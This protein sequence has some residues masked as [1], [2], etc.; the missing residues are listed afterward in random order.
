MLKVRKWAV[1]HWSGQLG[2]ISPQQ[3]VFLMTGDKTKVRTSSSWSSEGLEKHHQDHLWPVSGAETHTSSP[4]LLLLPD[5]AAV[6]RG[7]AEI[8]SGAQFNS[9]TSSERPEATLTPVRSAGL[10][11]ESGIAYLRVE[12][13]ERRC[14]SIPA[15]EMKTVSPVFS[16]LFFFLEEGVALLIT[17]RLLNPHKPSG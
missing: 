5:G 11:R 4:S 10:R 13:W 2:V 12:R 16:H 14:S 8:H 6:N 7:R 15:T 1:L 3:S 9:L 17:T